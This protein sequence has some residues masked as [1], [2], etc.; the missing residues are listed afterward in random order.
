M[1]DSARTAAGKVADVAVPAAGATV[2]GATLFG[3]NVPELIQYATLTL[4]LLQIVWWVFKLVTN[5][6]KGQEDGSKVVPAWEPTRKADGS[7][8]RKD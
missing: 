3:Y 2:S 1:I 7:T 4:L 8:D 6:P 5:V